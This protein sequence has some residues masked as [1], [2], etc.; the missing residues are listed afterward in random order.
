MLKKN[1]RI[2]YCIN[3]SISEYEFY[4]NGPPVIARQAGAIR[5]GIL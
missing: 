4:G 1:V 5:K 2:I 3:V